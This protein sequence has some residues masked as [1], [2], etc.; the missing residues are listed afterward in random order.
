METRAE[1]AAGKDPLGLAGTLA[2]KKRLLEAVG[3]MREENPM[4]GLRGVRLGI[5]LPQLV[6]MQVRAII[7]AACQCKREGIKVQPEDHDPAHRAQQRAQGRGRR[8]SRR[9]P[10]R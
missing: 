6:R 10:A 4:L 9:R 7:E 3:A 5:H 1:F 8:S 2:Q